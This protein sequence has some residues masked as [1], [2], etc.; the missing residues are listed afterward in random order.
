MFALEVVMK[1]RFH[2]VCSLILISQFVGLLYLNLLDYR[3]SICWTIVSQ[4]V[5]LSYLNLLDYRIS[6]C[7]TIVSQFVGLSYLNLLDC[8]ITNRNITFVGRVQVFTELETSAVRHHD[9]CGQ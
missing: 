9:T 2:I 8:R 3:I 7:W 6:I 5:G 4:F 1:E